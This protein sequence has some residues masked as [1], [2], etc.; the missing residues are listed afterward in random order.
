[1]AARSVRDRKRGTRHLKCI[2]NFYRKYDW[3][4]PFGKPYDLEEQFVRLWTAFGRS[5]LG[6][7]SCVSR[8]RKNSEY[9]SLIILVFVKIRLLLKTS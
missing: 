9:F 4:R 6:S 5:M 1:M 8:L 3:K 2:Q 7:R